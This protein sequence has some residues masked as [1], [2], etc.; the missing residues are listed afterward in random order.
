MRH[1]IMAI[2]IFCVSTGLFAQ[3]QWDDP[4]ERDKLKHYHQQNAKYIRY[5]ERELKKTERKLDKA[6]RQLDKKKTKLAKKISQV[7]LGPR[8]FFLVEDTRRRHIRQRCCNSD[9]T[10]CTVQGVF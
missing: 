4:A 7:Q 3:N 2:G 10:Y 1:L 6:E 5:L 8:P 9:D